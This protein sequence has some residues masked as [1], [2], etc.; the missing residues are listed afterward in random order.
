MLDTAIVDTHVHLWDPAQL[1]YA[2]HAEAPTLSRRYLLDEYRQACGSTD[3]E[4]MVFLECDCDH[5]Q[6]HDEVA[7]VTKLAEKDPRLQGIV[8]F[9]PLELGPSVG[10]E[11]A[12]LKK[13]PLVK[14]VRRI[15]QNEPDSDFCNRPEFVKGTRLLAEHGLSSDLCINHTQLTNN[16][17]LVQACPQVNFILDHIG[18]PDIRN[19]ET[20]PWAG[21]MKELSALPN[22]WCKLSGVVTEADPEN[23]TYGQISP[24]MQQ[25]LDCFGPERLIYGGDWP[26]VTLAAEYTR[27]VECIDQFLAQLNPEERRRVLHDNA[28]AFYRLAE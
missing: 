20:Q 22:A 7:M 23:W 21:G 12:K 17:R 19:G 16:V 24:Y 26:V 9:A 2:W 5:K 27:W 1:N 8:A 15:T 6:S 10:D 28:I 18:K 14:G 13:N 11:L 4:R 3:V 25:A